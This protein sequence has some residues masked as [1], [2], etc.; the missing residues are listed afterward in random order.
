LLSSAP[1]VLQ[2]ITGFMICRGVETAGIAKHGTKMVTVVI[3]GYGSYGAG[4]YS[5]YGRA[6][7]P[8]F[9]YMWPN[10]KISVM[11][12]E[13]AASVMATVS[14][15]QK[16]RNGLPVRGWSLIELVDEALLD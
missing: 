3:G 11:G 10:S 8:R 4:N 15:D 12:D 1:N 2:N 5:M 7:G 14:K 9:M 13:Q 16:E 6:Y